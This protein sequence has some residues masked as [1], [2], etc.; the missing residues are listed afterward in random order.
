MTVTIEDLLTILYIDYINQI[1]DQGNSVIVQKTFLFPEIG[2]IEKKS[3]GK[4]L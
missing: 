3:G 2:P 1:K 4:P